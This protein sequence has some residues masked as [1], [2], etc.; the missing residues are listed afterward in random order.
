MRVGHVQQSRLSYYDRNPSSVHD[1]IDS[2]SAPR[3]DTQLWTRTIASGKKAYVES[4]DLE[5]QRVTAATTVG[6]H[7]LRTIITPSG[8]AEGAFV[9]I[10]SLTNGVGDVAYRTFGGSKMLQ[11]GDKIECYT[12]DTSTGGSTRSL[13]NAHYSLFDA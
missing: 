9:R 4:V 10:E 7:G 2:S 1:V 3:G 5:L 11:A 6:A 8:G 12:F 13:A